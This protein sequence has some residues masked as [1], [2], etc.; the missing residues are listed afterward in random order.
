MK[1]ENLII[2][3][4]ILISLPL[5]YLG[6]EINAKVNLKIAG[7]GMTLGNRPE[8][9][10]KFQ[11]QK[12]NQEYL[13]GITNKEFS[14]NFKNF[15]L[16]QLPEKKCYI[17]FNKYQNLITTKISKVVC[18]GKDLAVYNLEKKQ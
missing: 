8:P 17:S 15:N 16:T 9:Y 6:G 5:F 11:L 12:D 10:Y 1:I 7:N 2:P 3:V 13:L 18:N 4:A 14:D